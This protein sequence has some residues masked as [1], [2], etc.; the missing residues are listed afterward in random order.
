LSASTNVGNV[1]VS[2][3]QIVDVAGASVDGV[4]GNVKVP[5]Q[6]VP[7]QNPVYEA[8]A[9]AV[10]GQG[11]S[12]PSYSSPGGI[13]VPGQALSTPVYQNTPGSV[14]AGQ[15]LSSAAYQEPTLPDGS[16]PDPGQPLSSPGYVERQVA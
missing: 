2:I 14:T 11:L 12:A 15:A 13:V 7:T 3:K 8:P 16:K 5:N 4:T 1:G 9:G 10:P 6:F